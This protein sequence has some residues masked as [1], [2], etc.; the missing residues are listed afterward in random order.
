MSRLR[1]LL[2]LV[3]VAGICACA[4][5]IPVAHVTGIRGQAS[6]LEGA[7]IDAMTRNL[8]IGADVFP[9]FDALAS[10]DPNDDVAALL[11]A[12]AESQI[13]AFPARVEALADEIANARPHVIGLQEVSIVDVLLPPFGV[14]IDLDYLALLQ[15]ALTRRGLQYVVAAQGSFSELTILPAAGMHIRNVDRD[16]LLIDA[17]RV[18][19]VEGSAFGGLFAHNVGDVGGG[20]VLTRGYVGAKLII[21]GV[22]VTVVNT[23]LE[24]LAGDVFSQLRAAQAAE[25]LGVIGSA[26]PALIIGDLNDVP[27]S[28]MHRLMT[29]AGFRDAWDDLRPGV[30]GLTC[31]HRSDL[32]NHTTSEAFSERIDYVM[33]RGI[34]HTNGRLLGSVT[35]HGTTP[36]DR[37]A[38]PLHLVWPSDHAGLSA[39][40]FVPPGN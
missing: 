27:G 14:E 40:L 1:Q 29:A 36:G 15:E 32:S 6:I 31:C 7:R 20:F 18:R 35:L 30:A 13:T 11:A 22:E 28:P 34:A 26:S 12:I 8:Y 19:I 33:A 25:I 9:V 38:G 39:Q 23:H 2:G 37:V 24:A 5:G 4:D 17:T 3:L 10:E 16:V 21:E